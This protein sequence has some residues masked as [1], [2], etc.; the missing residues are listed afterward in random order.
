MTTDGN[1]ELERLRQQLREVIIERDR[2]LAENCRLHKDYP[3]R[4]QALGQASLPLIEANVVPSTT[5]E[6]G[7][8]PAT[9][10]KESPLVLRQNKLLPKSTGCLINTVTVNSYL[11]GLIFQHDD[12]L[13]TARDV[14]HY[15]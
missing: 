8:G 3:R 6:S 11:V 13:L 4:P 7:I 12:G 1:E 9:I 15:H 14:P 5:A 10:N 2:L